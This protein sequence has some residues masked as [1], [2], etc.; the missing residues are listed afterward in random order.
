MLSGDSLSS[1]NMNKARQSKFTGARNQNQEGWNSDRFP[2]LSQSVA[3]LSNSIEEDEK[4]PEHSRDPRK[5]RIS[6]KNV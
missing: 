2:S 5:R 6:K 1:T 3:S 4:P